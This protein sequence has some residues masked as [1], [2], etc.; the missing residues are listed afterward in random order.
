MKW[1]KMEKKSKLYVLV[2][3]LWENQSMLQY[4]CSKW[5]SCHKL[6]FLRKIKLR[7]LLD[8]KIQ[9]VKN[10]VYTF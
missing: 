5:F 9:I 7:K 3:V 4:V 8:K 1:I 2:T 6:E 10:F